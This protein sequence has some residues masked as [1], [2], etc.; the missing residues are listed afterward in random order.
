MFTKKLAILLMVGS[1]MFL[2]FFFTNTRL[3][4]HYSDGMVHNH[5]LNTSA[6]KKLVRKNYTDLGYNRKYILLWTDPKTSPFIYFKEGTEIFK[7]K[8][9]RWSNCYV[10]G[11]RFLLGSYTKFD[12]VVFNG[13]QLINNRNK[14][15]LP[16]QRTFN[17]KFVYANIEAAS[18]Y[19][20]C[21][22]IWD[23]YF[24]WTWTYKLNS[25]AVW[26]YMTIKDEKG[27]V[28]GPNSNILWLR[29][30]EMDPI[31]DDLKLK[32]NSKTKAAAWFVSNCDTQ[33]QR[34]QYFM[35]LLRYLNQYN[36][37][38]DI[39]GECGNFKCPR[40]I[41]ERC[42]IMLE[43]DYYF[44]FAFENSLSEDYVTEKILHPVNH[45][46]VPI[47]LGGANYNRFMPPGSYINAIELGTV[48]LAKT[49]DALIKNKTEYHNMFKWKK[50]YSYHFKHESPDTDDYC[51]FCAMIN[52]STLMNT[53]SIYDN[54][55]MWWSDKNYC[56]DVLRW[57]NF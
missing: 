12:V 24:N 36:L 28:I 19:P 23:R 30:E 53:I 51:Q 32:L 44:Y 29:D 46:T 50:Y 48:K 15:D 33:S 8:K 47:V 25:D 7:Q 11:D 17:Q 26:G 42:L 45:Y 18:N 56:T 16:E 41:M 22:N 38:V 4:I 3:I 37:D 52:N 10:T 14:N 43:K 34:E 6:F 54:F 13:P 27:Q 49:M 21:T 35:E 55:D 39:F 1:I 9:C 2:L 5:L 40:N 20:I 31:S 57:E